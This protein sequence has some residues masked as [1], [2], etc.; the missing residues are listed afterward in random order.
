MKL[1]QKM[2]LETKETLIFLTKMKM[3][4]GFFMKSQILT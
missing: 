1:K 4:R 3:L 2:K